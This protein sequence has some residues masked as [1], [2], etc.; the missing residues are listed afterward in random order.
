MIPESSAA[1]PSGAGKNPQ[2]LG[3]DLDCLLD[4]L[5]G[6]VEMRD[7]AEAGGKDRRRDP[8]TRLVHPLERLGLR[9]TERLEVDLDEVRLHFFGVDGQPG[10]SQALAEPACPR[11]VL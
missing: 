2:S 6:D 5:V 9:E 8:D 1:S 10:R 3:D 11:V 7:R 4:V